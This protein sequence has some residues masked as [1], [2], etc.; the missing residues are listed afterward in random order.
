[1]ENKQ[2]K[3]VKLVSFLAILV[4]SSGC[5]KSQQVMDKSVVT[6]FELSRYL[7]TW[8]EIA[9]FDHCFE[10]DFGGNCHLHLK[11]DGMIKVLNSG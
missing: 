3:A 4:F 10:R 6:N 7:G 8:Y 1:M 11:D 5:L 2:F 9:R